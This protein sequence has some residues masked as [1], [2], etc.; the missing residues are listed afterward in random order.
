[1]SEN[2]WTGTPQAPF[3]KTSATT[4]DRR[5]FLRASGVAMALPFLESM[6][7]AF[8]GTSDTAAAAPARMVNI[9]NTLGIYRESWRPA[10]AG[11]GYEVTEYLELLDDHRDQYTLFSGY[12]HEEQT[13]RQPHNSEV[14]WLTAARGP[15]RDG[16]KNSISIDQA[17]ADHLGYVTRFP[18]VVMGTAS[19]Q[20][21]SYTQSGVMVPAQTS[22]A[23]LFGKLFLQGEPEEV[24]REERS[25]QSGGS[26]LDR[27]MSQTA[28]LRQRV[29][30]TD[31]QT[32]DAYF[33]AVRLA[34]T[35]LTEAGAWLKKPKP[36]VEEPVP[37]DVA[38][39]ADLV[40]RIRLWFNLI[41]L[42]LETDSSRVVSVMIQDH[43]VVPEIPGVQGDHHNLSHHGQDP[44][45]IEQLKIV[46]TEILK[47][48]RTLLDRLAEK[49]TSGA[50]LLDTTSVLFGSN[51][52]NANS[53]EPKDL[54]ILVAGGGFSHGAHVVHEG[55]RN[56]PLCN[57]YVT[58]LQRMGVETD[59]FGQSTGTL[60]WT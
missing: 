47:Q 31:Q 24:A 35:E 20:S 45:K 59:Q 49:D 4:L 10:Q 6:T 26:I 57:L 37:E 1:M 50:S 27:L 28:A 7:P 13:G 52:G 54:P 38:S 5:T 18:S 21:Q 48:L 33:D 44:A 41:P 53:H 43:Q 36:Q 19:E 30:A 23:G 39:K 14:T 25:L 11:R 51:L 12:S 55:E 16:F 42:I 2:Q 56:A 29:S 60:T 58:L 46:E 17:V 34:E 32:L 3:L 9:C 22:P 40:G 15:G 8:A